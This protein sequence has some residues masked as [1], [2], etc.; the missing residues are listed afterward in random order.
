M[1]LM[2]HGSGP[3]DRNANMP[4]QEL[5]IFNPISDALRQAGIRSYRYDKRG[6]ARSGGDFYSAGFTDLIKEACAALDI[7]IS[8]LGCDG[9]VLLG[10]SEGTIIAPVV[11]PLRPEVSGVKSAPH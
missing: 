5:N 1:V 6:C 11:A 10:H 7:L 3:L 2:L 4:G 9:F 8:D